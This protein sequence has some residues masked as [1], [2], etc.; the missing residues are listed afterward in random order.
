MARISIQN[1]NKR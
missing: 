1:L